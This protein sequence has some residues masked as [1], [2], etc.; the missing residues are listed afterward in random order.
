MSKKLHS[1][2]Y[3]LYDKANDHVLQ[4]SYGRVILFGVKDEAEEDCRGN[5]SVLSCTDLPQ[6]WQDIILTQINLEE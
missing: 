2:D 5:E 1:T 4:D 3:V 6:H